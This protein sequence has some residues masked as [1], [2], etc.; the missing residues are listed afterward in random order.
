M[1]RSKTSVSFREMVQLTLRGYKVWWREN[2]RLLLS[3]LTCGV[4]D[5]LTPYVSI[6]LLARLINEITGGHGPQTLTVYAL[7]LMVT[8]AV[9]S[10][11]GAGLT[12]WQD[13]SS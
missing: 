11:A 13:A 12:R 8:T 2:P 3:I 1:K 10:L 7:T 6:W 4:V 9:L 5:A